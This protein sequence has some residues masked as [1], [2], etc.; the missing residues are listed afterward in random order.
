MYMYTY[1]LSIYLYLKTIPGA[2][3]SVINGYGDEDYYH[4]YCYY[5]DPYSV[6]IGMYL[7]FPSFQ[8]NSVFFF[9]LAFSI[10]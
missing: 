10:I 7:W 9:F 1:I 3:G 4:Y 2:E 6:S 5:I 8:D